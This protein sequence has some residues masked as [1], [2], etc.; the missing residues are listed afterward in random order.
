MNSDQIGIR[1]RQLIKQMFGT[2]AEFR[3]GQLESIEHILTKSDRLLIVQKT[4]WGKS[5]VYFIMTKINRELGKGP[6]LIISPLLALMRN[7]IYNA[8]KL[9]L[10]AATINSSNTKEWEKIQNGLKNSAYD[11]LLISPERLSSQNFLSEIVPAMGKIGA[12]VV[13]EVHCISDWGHDFRP[14]YRRI[15]SIVSNVFTGIPIVGTTA[16]ANNRVVKDLEEQLG[17]GFSVMRGKLS[18]SGLKLQNIVLPT[19]AERLAWLADTIPK[20]KG[21]GVVYCLTRGDVLRVS[22][23]LKQCGIDCHHYWGGDIFDDNR[24]DLS[25]ILEQ[26]LLENKIKVIVATSALGMGY[27]KP[28]LNFVIHYQAPGSAIAYYQQVGRAGREVPESYGILLHGSEEDEILDYFMRE[29]FPTED[30]EKAVLGSLNTVTSATQ[31]EICRKLNMR[32]SRLEKA[33]KNLLIDGY[34]VKNGHDY[35]RTV[36][37]WAY[38]HQRKDQVQATR[39]RERE[40]MKTYISH[41]GCLMRFIANELDDPTAQDCGI[42]VNCNQSLLPTKPSL[43]TVQKAL[44]FLHQDCVVI[45]PRKR[46]PKGLELSVNLQSNPTIMIPKGE[47][48]EQGRA[49]GYL[50]NAGWGSVI[51]RCIKEN[52]PVPED[53]VNSAYYLITKQWAPNP[54]PEWITYIPSASRSRVIVDFAKRLGAKLR[55]TVLDVIAIS[56][57]SKKPI[58]KYENSQQQ[59]EN[60]INNWTVKSSTRKSPVLLIDDFVNSRWTLT[61]VGRSL[62]LHGVEKV[63][64][65]TMGSVKET[66]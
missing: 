40:R 10:R 15:K 32:S 41:E 27:D 56:N 2:S 12:F 53:I 31:G 42:C 1:S 60:S 45:D 3:P 13:D 35:S 21:S 62:R 18:R 30:E 44:E 52:N 46:W 7:Q 38:D 19:I 23:W 65:F 8:N 9:G 51:I 58:H 34:V 24:Q 28:D 43:S 29:A 26:K 6:T 39:I 64:P 17:S 54:I 4:G 63:Y 66:K 61:I 55:I 16:T 20:L 59:V 47:V 50:E 11:L 48:I 25:P 5:V 37:T 57:T 49:L 22:N 33:L 14:D 36:K